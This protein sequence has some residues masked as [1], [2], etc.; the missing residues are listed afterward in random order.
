M[1]LDKS[2]SSLHFKNLGSSF[3]SLSDFQEG[4]FNCLFG[5]SLDL[6]DL[7]LSDSSVDLDS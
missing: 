4:L 3:E 2:D 1:F 6:G 7:V 5:G